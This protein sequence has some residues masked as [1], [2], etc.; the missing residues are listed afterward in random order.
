M[1]WFA[2]TS[3]AAIISQLISI[4]SISV[5]MS[6]SLCVMETPPTLS[7]VS[8]LNTW[9]GGGKISELLKVP[10]RCD[11]VLEMDRLLY[12]YQ[13]MSYIWEFY[14]ICLSVSVHD[15][16]IDIYYIRLFHCQTRVGLSSVPFDF[17]RSTF[18]SHYFESALFAVWLIYFVVTVYYL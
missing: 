16:L 15:N 10:F 2:K 8:F 11:S 12:Q 9:Q 13:Y 6:S 3:F 1:G 4:F 18:Y 5:R 17:D 7:F 14:N